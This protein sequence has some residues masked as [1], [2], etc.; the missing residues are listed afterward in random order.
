[1]KI[2]E[3]WVKKLAILVA[4][5]LFATSITFF[6]IRLMPG[7]PV[8]TMAMSLITNE[9]LDYNQAYEKAKALL[10]YDPDKSF[11]EQYMS[12]LKDLSKL[13]LGES[14]SSKQPVIKVI[15]GALPWTLFI[16][17]ISV[18]IAFVLGVLIGMYIAWN[19]NTLIDPIVSV[20][21]SISGSLPDYIV[22]LLLVVLFSTKLRWFPS[23]GAYSSQVT[24][25][26]NFL[27]IKDVLYHSF[28]PMLTYVITGLG[29][30]ALFMKGSAVSVLSED[31]IMAA[32][33]RGL[34]EKR[35]RKTYVGRNA[36]L[37][38]ITSLAI[39]FG[40]L[41]GGS[42]L[43][44]N[45]FAYPGVGFYLN[46]AIAARDYSLMQGMFLMITIAVVLAN[47]AAD[48]CNILL[49]PRIKDKA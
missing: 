44:E 42:P 46:R 7:D 40:A 19:R 8:D 2:V 4:T 1:M 10:N 29:S 6:V 27:F 35:I 24:P 28:L 3:V 26:F 49:D 16:L 23:R 41:F 47:L 25:G 21:A 15:A 12:Y 30:W 38:L 34:S 39:S 43:I 11:G 32:R 18:T 13:E 37:P 5:I 48:F 31:Y 17:T 45:L 14:M 33:A 9:G 36:I 20:Y 22:G